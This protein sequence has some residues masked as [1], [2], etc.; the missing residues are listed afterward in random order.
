[1][2][3]S[4]SWGV[5]ERGGNRDES[6]WSRNFQAKGTTQR[7]RR[8]DSERSSHAV[9]ETNPLLNEIFQLI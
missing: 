5:L 9:H 4:E 3:D 7:V 2:R 8:V 1:M 6:C